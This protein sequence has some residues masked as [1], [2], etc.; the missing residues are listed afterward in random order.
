LPIGPT[1]PT[2]KVFFVKFSLQVNFVE[3]LEQSWAKLLK[4]VTAMKRLP[5]NLLKKVTVL[6]RFMTIFLKK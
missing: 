6:K 1:G 4:K 2:Q 5:M 3:P